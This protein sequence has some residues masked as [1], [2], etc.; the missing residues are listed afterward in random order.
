MV[1]LVL[2][3]VAHNIDTINS[4]NIKVYNETTNTYSAYGVSFNYPNNWDA[5]TYSEQGSDSIVLHIPLNKTI[6]ER[7]ITEEPK[8][9][10]VEPVFEINIYKNLGNLGDNDPNTIIIDTDDNNSTD[11]NKISK[12]T[13]IIDGNTA[14]EDVYI[15]NNTTSFPEVY[16]VK[17]IFL[18]KKGFIYSISFYSPVNS[19]DSNKP[20]FDMILNSIKIQ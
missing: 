10:V 3:L 1:A 2:I 14:I 13:L 18:V 8:T 17:E 9:I 16:K 5:S 7:E 15:V 4:Q 20:I 19:F 11:R 6:V 12:R